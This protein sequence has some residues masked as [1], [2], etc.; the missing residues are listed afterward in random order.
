MAA[1]IPV[2]TTDGESECPTPDGRGPL[3]YSRSMEWIFLA[4]VVMALAALAL[5]LVLVLRPRRP[6][7]E[8][9][10]DRI[11]ALTDAQERTE[12]T[13][14]EELGRNRQELAAVQARSAELLAEQ[15]AGIRSEFALIGQGNERRLDALRETVDRKLAAIQADN[16]ERLES[17][18]K[19]VDEKLHETLERRLG[20][21]F[22]LVGERLE[23]VQSGL[24]EMRSLA[25]GV[26]DLKR[27]LANVKNRG[28]WGE[29]Q[30]LSIAED[31]LAPGQYELNAQPRPGVSERVEL[32]VR[33]PGK[34]GGRPV[35]LPVDAK[36]PKED[37]ERLVDARE[38]GDAAAAADAAKALERRFLASAKEIREKYVLPP[39]TTDFAVM[40]LPSEGLFAECAGRAGMAERLQRDYRVVP[41]GPSTLA[42][43]L[44]SLQMGFR[45]FAVEQRS[46][47]VW[48]ALSQVRTE[49]G[50]FGEL[51]D[52]TRKKL[53]EAA[54]TV[55]DASRKS[56][57]IGGRL[58]KVEELAPQA[59]LGSS[60]AA[61]PLPRSTTRD[62]E[63]SGR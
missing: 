37:Y 8:R 46:S 3:V 57:T 61:P 44:N 63:E 7:A 28:T 45:A 10:D 31:I 55:D 2:A 32:A 33:L 58:A 18:R 39:D 30:L 35:L 36:F 52:K 27:V 20:D 56:R 53:Q 6:G 17:M 9:R 22:K 38:R 25:A 13:L 15:L 21:S 4:V 59:V 43:L 42:A 1:T 41:A 50:K 40:F 5:V 12:R 16:A 23:Q 14:R 47:E 26:G 34:D 54:D 49:F 60:D 11:L 48:R 19:T 29:V 62:S 51:L 24:G